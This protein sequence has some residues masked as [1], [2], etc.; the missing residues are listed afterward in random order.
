[1]GAHFPA[2]ELNNA[3]RFSTLSRM[4]R[5]MRHS[6][7]WTCRF[8]C[9]LQY[10]S[11]PEVLACSLNTDLNYVT[12]ILQRPFLE[13]L[14]KVAATLRE[15]MRQLFECIL[16]DRYVTQQCSLLDPRSCTEF[17]GKIH[18]C[19]RSLADFIL[20]LAS[21]YCHYIFICYLCNS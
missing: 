16:I 6:S 21:L 7:K 5:F 4:S 8:G 18:K 20:A 13:P 15:K 3:I 19:L 17:S 2:A 1:M 9:F 14:S 11:G 10:T 12:T